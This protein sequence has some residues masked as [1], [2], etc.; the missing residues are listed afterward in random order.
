MANS[1]FSHTLLPI[2]AFLAKA[3]YILGEEVSN[4]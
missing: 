2:V 3:R 4:D 1:P